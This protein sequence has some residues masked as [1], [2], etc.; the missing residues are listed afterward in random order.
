M[1][2][3]TRN[4]FDPMDFTPVCLDKINNR[5]RRVTTSGFELALS[6]VFT[7]GIQHYPEIPAGMAKM[8]DYVKDFMRKVPGIWDDTKFIDGYPGKFAVLARK[9]NGKWIVAGIN[10]ENTERKL[11]LNLS[12]LPVGKG[13]LITDGNGELF[14][15]QDVELKADK[16]LDI[17]LK[18]NGGFVITFE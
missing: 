2:P 12:E 6:V 7:S 16:K 13:V 1:L 9:G 15:K 5:I 18:P 11:S 10:A 14:A 4:V 3:F 8:P 17:T